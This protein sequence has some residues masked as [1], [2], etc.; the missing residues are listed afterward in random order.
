MIEIVVVV[1]PEGP[2]AEEARALAEA[3]A[4][5]EEAAEVDDLV[6]TFPASPFFFPSTS[7]PGAE[8]AAVA[9]AAAAAVFPF[10]VV[11]EGP[12]DRFVAK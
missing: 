7:P 3:A 11:M 1:V 9:A 10:V 2:G 8:T 5:A 12:E 6:A 4:T